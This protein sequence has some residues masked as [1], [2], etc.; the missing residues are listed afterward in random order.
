MQPP[1]PPSILGCNSCHHRTTFGVAGFTLIELSIVLVIIG[2][3]VGGVMVGQNLIFA[4]EIRKQVKQ[5]QEYTLA[6]NTFKLKYGCIPGDCINAT[7]F[8]TSSSNGNG[9]GKLEISLV[10][11]WGV[12]TELQSDADGN[13]FDYEQAAFFQHLILA[14]FITTD[15]SLRTL[16]YPEPAFPHKQGQGFIAANGFQQRCADAAQVAAY[17]PIFT[18]QQDDCFALNKWRIGLYFAVG[19]PDDPWGWKNDKYGIFTPVVT[20]ALDL[21]LDDGKPQTG[22]FRGGTIEWTDDGDGGYCL[23]PVPPSLPVALGLG[24][25]YNLTETRKQCIFAWRLE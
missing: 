5:V 20:Y 22:N 19:N 6:Y 21:K 13:A 17:S 11:S 2:L 25:E 1:P 12:S 18:T 14:N 4:A 3:I 15:N 9:N 16:G 8:F 7:E 10:W 23:S 24:T